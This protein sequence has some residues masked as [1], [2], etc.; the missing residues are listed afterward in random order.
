MSFQSINGQQRAKQMLQNGLRNNKISHAYIFS[1][2]MGT[3]KQRM[4]LTLAKAIFCKERDDD[5]CGQC[6]ECRKTENHN[7]PG[8]HWIKPDG[9]AIK[10]EQIRGLQKEFSYRAASFQS[11]VY[12]IQEAERMTVQAANSLLKF[13]EEPQSDI[14]AILITEN[15]HALLPT[16]RS[17]AQWIPFVPMAPREMVPV[18]TSEGFAEE[19]I[20]PAVRLAAGLDAARELIQLNWFAEIRGVVIQLAKE[21]LTRYASALITAQQKVIK[22]E[23]AEHM[24]TLFDLLILWYK[25]MIYIQVDRKDHIVFIDQIDWIKRHAFT[26]EPSYWLGCM[27]QAIEIQKRLRF[28]VNPQLALEQFMIGIEGG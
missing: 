8:L 6:L 5:A 15:G 11:K 28:Y 26:R 23:L 13:L 17:R 9:A 10:I 7:H 4:A 12:I 24:G 25:D 20:H 27:E 14:V 1:G 21:C 2:P 22:S 16:I 19:L 18:L 3:G